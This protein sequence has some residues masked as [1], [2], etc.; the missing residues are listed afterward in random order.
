MTKLYDVHPNAKIGIN[1]KIESFAKIYDDVVIGDNCTIGSGAVIMSGTRIGDNTHVFPGAVLGADPQDL[2]FKGENTTLE[3]GSNV[4]IREYCTL[5][6]GTSANQKTVIGDNCLLMAYVHVGHDCEIGN[7]CILAN[8]TTL[9]GHIQIDDFARIGGMTAIH[10]F[11]RIGKHAM[12]QGGSLVGKDVPPYTKAARYPLS[13]VGINSIGLKRFGYDYDQIHHIQDIYRILYV[14]GHNVKQAVG[15][16]EAEID[17]S[18]LRDEIL[19]FIDSSNR[20]I[21]KGF[22]SLNGN[23]SK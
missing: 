17:V 1:V 11:C 15:Y 10:Q 8:N 12:L 7:A 23:K 20:G 21:M 2:K 13:Y 9:G 19:Q 5:N 4:T 18:E 22:R 3:I 6:R 14:R 16:I